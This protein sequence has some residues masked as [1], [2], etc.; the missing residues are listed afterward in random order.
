M[1]Q[2]ETVEFALSDEITIV[3]DLCGPSGG[4]PILFLHGGGQTRHSW[5]STASRL[6]ESGYRTLSMDLRGHGDSSWH[7]EGRYE[8]LDHAADVAAIIDIVGGRPV[9][10]GASLGGIVGMILEGVHRPGSIKGLALVDI[11]P[12]MS[13]AGADRILAFMF[14]KAEEGFGSLDEV[15]DAVAAYNPH[16]PRPS[17]LDGLKKNV[18]QRDGR[19]YW[20]WDPR[21][22]SHAVGDIQTVDPSTTVRN[23]DKLADALHGVHLPVVLVR[24]RQSDI[25]TDVQV[26]DF[27]SE[28]PDAG[29]VDISGAGHMVAGD[30]NDPFTEAVIDFITTV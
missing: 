14:D 6:A 23:A 28:F 8:L 29:F 18:R 24:G 9:L 11:V 10:V 2:S 5:S 22:F 13:A 25:V 12:R 30:Q 1:T 27:C 16:R 19:W 15:A 3:A 4:M 7:P 21:A 26:A 20:H 17:N